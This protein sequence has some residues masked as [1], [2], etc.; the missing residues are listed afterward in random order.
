[1]SS[2]DD[3]APYLIAALGGSEVAKRLVG[4]VKWWQVRGI[5]GYVYVLISLQGPLTPFSAS[6]GSG[7]QPRRTI[8]KRRNATKSRPRGVRQTWTRLARLL[9]RRTSRTAP[10]GPMTKI[11]TLCVVFSTCMEGVTT[12]VVWIRKGVLG[13]ARCTSRRSLRGPQI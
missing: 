8:R 3:A 2:C 13:C 10:T 4:G 5:N 9:R 7:S 1:M 6:T 11:W 12:L